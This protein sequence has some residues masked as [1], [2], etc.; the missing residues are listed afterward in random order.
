MHLAFVFLRRRDP[1][2]LLGFFLLGEGQFAEPWPGRGQYAHEAAGAQKLAARAATRGQVS[3]QGF[4]IHFIHVQQTVGGTRGRRGVGKV[5]AKHA[6]ALFIA[7]AKQVSA[8]MVACR[9]VF[10]VLMVLTMV[11]LVWHSLLL[12]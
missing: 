10:L 12:V 3:V 2:G 1:E 11:M 8:V 6:G 4:L 7:T 5:L 9:L